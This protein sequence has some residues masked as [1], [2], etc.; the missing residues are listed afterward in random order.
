[1]LDECKGARLEEVLAVF[2]S[3]VLK[4][5]IAEKQLNSREYPAVAQT[6]ALENRG[7]SG[8]RS[9]L[10]FLV[11]AHK[12]SLNRTL[13]EKNTARAQYKGFA[14][15]LDLKE[16]DIER[17]RKQVRA[18]GNTGRNK[19][20]DDTKLDVRRAVR[21][22]WAGNERWMEA[23][24]CGDAGSRKDGVL[25]AP[26]DRVWRRVQT[27]RLAELEDQSGGLLKQLDSRVRTQQERLGKWTTFQKDMFG[28][29]NKKTPETSDKSTK[30]K[31]G[32]DLNFGGH[33]SLHLGRS[34]PRKIHSTKSDPLSRE[35][36]DL[37]HDLEKE[38]KDINK[39]SA[40]PRL[41]GLKRQYPPREPVAEEPISELSELEEELAKSYD[42]PRGK[43]TKQVIQDAPEEVPGDVTPKPAKRL[44]R[45]RLP[46]PLSTLLPPAESLDRDTESSDA[47]SKHP[48]KVSRPRIPQAT[49]T[50]QPIGDSADGDIESSDAPVKRTS[51][52]ARPRAPAS[53]SSAKVEE[54]VSRPEPEVED[55]ETP[56]PRK[57]TRNKV[58]S[59][60]R[61]PVRAI[62]PSPTRSPLRT[63]SPSPTRSPDRVPIPQAQSPEQITESPTQLLADQILAS[64]DAASPSP[65]KKPK[66]RHT[67][68]LAE[69]ARLSM[70]RG[71]HAAN[72]DDDDHDLISL[73]LRRRNT[74][75]RTPD[76]TK[77]ISK[78]SSISEDTNAGAAADDEADREDLA[79]RTRRSM[80]NFDA[81]RQ[82]VQL[83]RQRSQRKEA[84]QQ[85]Q[86]NKSGE[87]ARQTYFAPVEEETA[88]G[89]LTG[90]DGK[91]TLLLAE[92]LMAKEKEG[93]EAVDYADVFKSRPKI[94]TSPP[95]TPVRR[96]WD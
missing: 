23:V 7:Y 90:G 95:R 26:Y 30:H 69:R 17:R 53:S 29:T 68:S 54:Q 33:E 66:P 65:V 75:S 78:S 55:P 10:Q 18:Q 21:N 59:P 76:K 49:A 20:S 37:I 48:S 22:N 46:R 8:E 6:L 4:N 19:V 16:R 51:R 91:S 77:P 67:L 93:G 84:R 47:A 92:E 15:L 27:G 41:A 83:Q 14:E 9:Q 36:D 79:A 63:V 1:M 38:L 12:V 32:I 56:R 5:I 73:P 86:S 45:P 71:P 60:E 39:G 89:G 35:Y 44:S 81:V 40:A 80:A 25:T 58:I 70:G 43:S 42:A 61:T 62:S 31:K 13:K 11:L 28:D 24:L 94:A 50:A 57:L 72:V 96:G 64:M 87:I 3:A 52:P 34:S 74:S 2:S 82:N 85:S 88:D